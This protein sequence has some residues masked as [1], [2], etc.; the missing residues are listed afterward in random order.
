MKKVLF[1]ILRSELDTIK[2]AKIIAAYKENNP[3]TELSVLTY[4]EF[5]QYAN[6]LDDVT[7][8][9]AIDKKEI[10]TY[11]NG[12]VYSDGLALNSFASSMEEVFKTQWN[13]VVNL[14]NDSVSAY[15]VSGLDTEEIIGSH[16]GN[17]G[18]NVTSNNWNTYLNSVAATESI[19]TIG[20][21]DVRSHMLS[22]PYQDTTCGIKIDENYAREAY[23]NFA[24]IRESKG[25]SN[26]HIIAVSITDGRG[27]EYID[28]ESMIELI[29]TLESSED[30][31]VVLLSANSDY[32]REIVNKLNSEF[33]N[34]LIT[35]KAQTEAMPAVMS[36]IDGIISCSNI[37]LALAEALDVFSIEVCVDANN[38]II[39]ASNNVIIEA[40]DK[41]LDDVF[42][43]LNKRFESLLPV[44]SMTS[45]NA[46]FETFN[47]EY[48]SMKS[49]TRGPV[50]I[51]RELNYHLKRCYNY[52]L[53]GYPVNHDLLR[54]LQSNISK[55]DMTNYIEEVKEEI[56]IYVKTLL[57]A[58]RSLKTTK[59]NGQNTDVFIKCLDKLITSAKDSTLPSGALGLLEGRIEN[60]TSTDHNDNIIQIERYLFELKSDLQMLTNIFSDL[61]FTK[62]VNEATK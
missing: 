45:E 13:C 44:S 27:G 3:H 51:N 4:S 40:R 11:L 30:Y 31:K 21:S 52:A 59:E 22:A 16:T 8:V 56:T 46:V 39:E 43:M 23:N 17:Y 25:S 36:N 47:D 6:L 20:L 37:T 19:R 35:I 32:E 33:N 60:I 61:L 62:K 55:E 28:H 54:N 10:A 41:Y 50:D 26:T 29:D 7:S 49:L 42:Y 58:L 34:S 48:G 38:S 15:L 53:L 12:D 2:S 14:S 18:S 9:Y 1:T 5:E 24:K 57:T